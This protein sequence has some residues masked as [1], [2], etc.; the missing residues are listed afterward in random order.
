[1]KYWAIFAAA[2]ALLLIGRCSAPDIPN[3][4]REAWRRASRSALNK[5]NV[6]ID[7]LVEL[8]ESHKLRADSLERIAVSRFMKAESRPDTTT[9]PEANPSDSVRYWRSQSEYERSQKETYR[10]A[11]LGQ[12][13]VTISERLR[14]SVAEEARDSLMVVNSAL[15]GLLARGVELSEKADRG[16]RVLYLL[17]CPVPY[18]G[19]GYDLLERAPYLFAGVATDGRVSLYAEASL[20]RQWQAAS[21][22]VTVTF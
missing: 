19:G 8:G 10:E 1:M 2:A 22:G 7:S 11:Y 6:V 13:Q 16:C 3:W 21:V 9:P 18:L 14:A 20:G 15:K 4:E 12:V 17:P 5:K